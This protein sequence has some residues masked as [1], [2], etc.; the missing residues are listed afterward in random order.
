MIGSQIKKLRTERGMTQKQLADQLFV[1]AQAVSRWENEEV[2]P[3]VS[4]I[5]EMAKI[6]GVSTDVIFGVSDETPAGETPPAPEPEVIVQTEYVYKE[7]K[8]VLAVCE[9]CNRPIYEGGEI[10]R[11]TRYHYSG[12]SK[13]STQHILCID[14]DRKNKKNAHD[15]AVGRGLVLRR[16]SFIWGILGALAVLGIMLGVVISQ[17]MFSLIPLAVALPIVTF[18][19][20]SCCILQ[21]NFIGD[22][23]ETITSWGIHL[24][25]LIFSLDLEGIIWLLTVKL[26]LWILGIL[27]TILLWLLAFA[28]G[29]A[30]SLFVYPYAIGKN[31]KHPE[32][33][34]D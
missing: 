23:M 28:V 12:R 14:C 15:A 10:V 16:R 20:I 33:N 7:Q 32:L 27:G 19:L 11:N 31:F 6:F 29:G 22:L 26:A 30:L 34:E 18:T 21:N 17:S 1:S 24:P 13:T 3:S 8:P 5:T 9:Q 2:E 25:G 4:T